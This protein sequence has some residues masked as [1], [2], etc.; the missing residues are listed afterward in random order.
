MTETNRETGAPIRPRLLDL[1][2]GGGG[3]AMGYW[4]AGFDVYGIDLEKMPDYPFWFKRG[5]AL[6]V[7]LE[8]FDAIHASPPCQAYSVSVIDKAKHP[9]LLP[10][11]RERLLT[12]GV[13]WVIEN[14]PGAPMRADYTLCGTQFALPGLRRHR[15]FETS[16]G[17]TFTM[18][19][20]CRHDEPTVTVIGHG[21]NQHS[22]YRHRSK[23]KEWALLKQ[24]AMGIDWIGDREVLSEAIP[25]A[26][27]ELVGEHLMAQVRPVWKWQYGCKH[28][29]PN[30]VRCPEGC[31][32][33]LV[34]A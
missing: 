21:P 20:P 29:H 33:K 10:A 28:G 34:R 8:G 17:G 23:G 3:A 27:T 9:D 22:Y 16:W 1:C 31:D 6:T 15:L 26:Y 24:K 7:P 14:V 18:L 32:D 2:C 13:P 12:S 25:P 11:I 19:P 5:D 30:F 4:R